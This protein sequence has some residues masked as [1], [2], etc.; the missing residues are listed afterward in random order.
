MGQI[1]WYKRDPSEA[2]NG[3]MELTLEERGAYNTILDLIYSRD[4]NLPDD[5]RFVAGWLRVDVRVWKRIKARLIE[6]QKLYVADGM[7]RNRRAD[8]EILMALSRAASAREAG[9]AS[10]RSKAAK[11]HRKSRKI[12]HVASTTVGTGASTGVSTNHNQNNLPSEDIHLPPEDL[13]SP[14][15][16]SH[17]AATGADQM[18]PDRPDDVV[19]VEDVVEGWNDLAQRCD[20]PSIRRLSEARRRQL[21]ARLRE[22][23][24]IADWKRAF[25]AI[26]NSAFLRGDNSRGWRANFDFLLQPS[27]FL[28]LLE[29]AY[30][31][32][33]K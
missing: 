23:P 16:I 24:D 11:S 4:G 21:K 20:L 27:S 2:L 25:A 28:K 10:A 13:V 18:T 6:R 29:G 26:H 7:L 3:M 32:T 17:L 9:R 8:A 33:H 31:E 22:Y 5:D 1:K 12:K 15:G 30:D 14:S 19:T